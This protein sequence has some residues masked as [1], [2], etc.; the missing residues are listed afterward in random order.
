MNNRQHLPRRERALIILREILIQLFSV[1]G[2]GSLVYGWE[3]FF[4]GAGAHG[5][6]LM[7]VCALIVFILVWKAMEG[8]NG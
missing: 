4:K 5:H 1:A 6:A 7:A 3:Y 2:V 8:R